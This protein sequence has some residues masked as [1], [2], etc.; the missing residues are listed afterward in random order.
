MDIRVFVTGGTFDKE[1]DELTGR[2]YFKD[3]HL[4]EM[5]SLARSRVPTQI[6]TLMMVDSLEMT[7]ADRSIIVENCLRATEE[8]ILVTHGTDTMEITA[9]ALGEKV[10]G[11][12]IVLTGAM[13]PYKFGSSDGLFNL[14]SAMAFAQTLPHGVYIA[15]NGRCFHWT[16]VQKNRKT[17]TFEEKGP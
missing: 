1:Y 15:M 4:P 11:K 7:E 16:N 13:I 14:G 6:R 3:T 5:L 9:R 17:G 10:K 12:T 8:R 2:L